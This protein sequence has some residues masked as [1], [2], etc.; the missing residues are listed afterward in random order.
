MAYSYGG[1]MKFFSVIG[2]C[3][4]SNLVW[5]AEIYQH[6][7]RQY[8]RGTGCESAAADLSKRFSIASGAE[9]YWAGTEKEDAT[10]CDLTI[11]YLADKELEFTST[12]DLS[13]HGSSR[14]GTARSLADCM[15]DLSREIS[16]FRKST[17]LVP[18]LSYC[19]QENTLLNGLPFV[20]VVEGF[21]N[22]T[23]RFFTS[24]SIVGITPEI[25]WNQML[26]IL[27]KNASQQGLSIA[28]VVARPYL[29]ASNKEITV[30]YYSRE[31]LYLRVEGIAEHSSS[32][33]C[34]EQIADVEAGLATAGRPPLGVYCGKYLHNQYRLGIIGLTSDVLGIANIKAVEDPKQFGTLNACRAALPGMLDLYRDKLGKKVLTGMCADG[35]GRFRITVIEELTSFLLEGGKEAKGSW[36][37]Q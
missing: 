28:S 25:G 30:R 7:V 2:I 31:R 29:T 3:F 9:V 26:S 21:G 37:H 12:L 22:S 19:Y 17:G 18:W 13:G 16:V 6:K 27:L 10:T 1:L 34:R 8:P 15:A 36:N 20:P 14:K 24:E 35:T 33:I 23:L 32:A 5:G 11:S 4:V